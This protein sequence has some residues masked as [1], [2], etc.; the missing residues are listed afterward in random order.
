VVASLPPSLSGRVASVGLEDGDVV[1]G[2]RGGAEVHYGAPLA[3]P[4]KHRALLSVLRWAREHRV[5]TGTVD[6]SF[7]RMPTLDAER[8]AG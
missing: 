3:L 1:Q 7:P 8:I 4:A 6:V 2:I 5:E